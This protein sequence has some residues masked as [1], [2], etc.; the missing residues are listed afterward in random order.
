MMANVFGFLGPN[1]AG[2]TTTLRVLLGLAHAD[3][4]EALIDGRRYA[5][6]EDPVCRVG[7]VVDGI[8]FHPRRTARGHLRVVAAAA[9]IP[10]ARIADVLGI[11]ELERSAKRKVGG[12]SLGMRQRL[13]L[14]TALLGDPEIL[15]LDEP[16]NGLDPA[17]IRWL[18]DFLR[19][20]AHGGRTVVVSS[21]LLAEVAQM[22][23]EAVVVH[24]GRLVRQAPIDELT[25]DAKSLE[26]VF[27]ELTKEVAR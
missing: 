11:V 2:K 18:R 4:G 14:A 8:G 15:I 20:Y 16:A 21:H 24:R 23:D 12:F 22:A 25:R 9:G 1:G 19:A 17:G 10:V 27:F 6:L 5:E 13:A 3:S 26:D 7:A